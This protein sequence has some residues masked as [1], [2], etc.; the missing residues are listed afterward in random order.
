MLS[1][2]RIPKSEAGVCFYRARNNAE[3]SDLSW[4]DNV[5]TSVFECIM[6]PVRLPWHWPDRV[7]RE[8]PFRGCDMSFGHQQECAEGKTAVSCSLSCVS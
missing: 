1:H 7:D 5:E 8:G 3:E 6:V 4:R 2:E